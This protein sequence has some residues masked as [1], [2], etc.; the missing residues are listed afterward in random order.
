MKKTI[1][2]LG[3]LLM[4]FLVI[5]GCEQDRTFPELEDLEHG[6]FPRLITPPGVSGAYAPNFNY[7]DVE[8][9]T[10]SFTVEFY[11]DNQGQNVESYS[12]TVNHAPTGTSAQIASKNRSQ[13]G[14]SADGLPSADF[15]FTFQQALDALGLTIDQVNGGESIQFYA[16]VTMSDGRV[17]THSNTSDILEGQPA[18]RAFYQHRAS[19]ICPSTLA[20][21]F[22]ATTVGKGTWAGSACTSTWTGTVEWIHEGN[23]IYN[24]KSTH[25]GEVFTDMAMGGYF[26]CYNSG[27]QS[28]L[29]NGTLRLNDACGKLFYSGQSQ[30]AE[31]YVFNSIT[32]NGNTLVL[33]W[34]NDYGE[35]ATTTLVRTDGKNWP[36]NLRK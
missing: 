13:F 16:T 15:T 7:N 10:L 19:I 22:D 34:E 35:T 4:S 23:G 25:N 6:A 20:G 17:F 14:T 11:D 2:Y 21:V 9:S 18:Y 12:W 3:M 1:Y 33:D 32:V 8:G 36:S 26:A 30:W 24:V 28:S 5:T 27:A 31:T 29:P